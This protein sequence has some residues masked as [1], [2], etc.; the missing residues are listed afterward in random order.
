[1]HMTNFSSYPM[2]FFRSRKKIKEE[3]GENSPTLMGGPCFLG[4]DKLDMVASP[5]LPFAATFRCSCLQAGWQS[6]LQTYNPSVMRQ[7][8]RT[9]R[10][11]GKIPLY[12]HRVIQK[13]CEIVDAYF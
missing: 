4:L 6:P 2:V 11:F 12:L 1:M 13:E 10:Q 7:S 3:K 9:A 5:P 8:F